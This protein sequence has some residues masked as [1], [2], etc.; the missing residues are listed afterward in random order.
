LTR[1]VHAD[2]LRQS[3]NLPVCLNSMDGR[4]EWYYV[5]KYGKRDRR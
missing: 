4:V 3:D 5:G 1:H 2:L